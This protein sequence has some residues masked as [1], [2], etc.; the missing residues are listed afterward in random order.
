MGATAAEGI[1]EEV[2][3]SHPDKHVASVRATYTQRGMLTPSPKV[4]M[5]MLKN[6]P[7]GKKKYHFFIYLFIPKPFRYYLCLAFFFFLCYILATGHVIPV[8]EF[9]L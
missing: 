4:L 8:S 3:V 9:K 6:S 7:L 5:S 1:Q 2:A